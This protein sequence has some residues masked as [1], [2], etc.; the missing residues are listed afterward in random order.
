M[1]Q[2]H[3]LLGFGSRKNVT[4]QIIPSASGW[5]P[6]LEGPFM[7]IES[8]AG[9]RIVHVEN[10]QAGLFFHENIDVHAYE[11]AVDMVQQV[12]LTTTESKQLIHDV[13]AEVQE[14]R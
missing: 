2:L 5:S 11:T 14:E 10:R 13:A 8:T 12:A 4:I 3:H 7:L 1:D 6:A 9:D